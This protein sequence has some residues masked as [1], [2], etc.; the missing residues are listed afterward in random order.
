MKT[1]EIKNVINDADTFVIK[2]IGEIEKVQSNLNVNH[3]EALQDFCSDIIK[4]LE[5]IQ[6]DMYSLMEDER[7]RGT[8]A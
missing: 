4:K 8:D 7:L 2:S 6:E 1:D 5:E 3:S